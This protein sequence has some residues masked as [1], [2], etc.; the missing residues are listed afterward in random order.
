[1]Y[2]VWIATATYSAEGDWCVLLSGVG[3]NEGDAAFSLAKVWD[4][5]SGASKL[6]FCEPIARRFLQK[7]NLTCEGAKWLLHKTSKLYGFHCA[8]DMLCMAARSRCSYNVGVWCVTAWGGSEDFLQSGWVRCGVMIKIWYGFWLGEGRWVLVAIYRRKFCCSVSA[9]GEVISK[10]NAIA[11]CLTAGIFVNKND[12]LKK[13]I[14]VAY[15]KQQAER[16]SCST[17]KTKHAPMPHNT[18]SGC[19][20]YAK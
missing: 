2:F 20:Y 6:D 14:L 18:A 16:E 7:N 8:H 10:D 1:M 4:W 19:G 5:Q 11:Q 15:W 13:I 3:L 9:R 12:L 17:Y